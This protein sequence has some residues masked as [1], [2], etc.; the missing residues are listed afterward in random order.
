MTPN[1]S[2]ERTLSETLPSRRD[3]AA[4][5]IKQRKDIPMKT[6]RGKPAAAA[7]RKKS[8]SLMSR[9]TLSRREFMAVSAAAGAAILTGT[10]PVSRGRLEPLG[11]LRKQRLCFLQISRVKPL[12]KPAVNLS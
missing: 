2:I 12:S 4:K 11:Q 6:T 3:G 8:T 7:D 10:L 1:P 9:E 5:A